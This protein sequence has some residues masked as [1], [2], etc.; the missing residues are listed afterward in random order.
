M[1]LCGDCPPW[2][3]WNELAL[4]VAVANDCG[5]NIVQEVVDQKSSS[6]A[7]HEYGVFAASFSLK[8]NTQL[9]SLSTMSLKSKTSVSNCSEDQ[10]TRPAN[11]E[12]ESIVG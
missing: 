11:Q 9:P 1:G 8:C 3:L 5:R 6:F 12:S 10:L 7:T 2:L 4:D